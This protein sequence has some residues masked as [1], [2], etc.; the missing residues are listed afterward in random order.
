MLV[1]MFARIGIPRVF[2]KGA[3]LETA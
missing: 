1:G 3:V 2:R